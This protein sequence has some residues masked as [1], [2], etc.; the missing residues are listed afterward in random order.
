MGLAERDEI[1]NA[2]GKLVD[3][4]TFADQEGPEALWKND[5][6]RGVPSPGNLQSIYWRKRFPA[7]TAKDPDRDRCG[8]LWLCPAFPLDGKVIETA[9]DKVHEICLLCGFEPNIGLQLASP[10]CVHAFVMLVYDREVAGEDERAL[11]CHDQLLGYLAGL[12]IYP[13]RLALPALDRLPPGEQ[14]YGTFMKKIKQAL[15]PRGILR[16]VAMISRFSD[17]HVLNPDG[18]THGR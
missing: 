16:P 2:L 8:V 11:A 17:V 5:L 4:L 6:F 14:D 1:A 12:G 18:N 13:Y 7:P 3:G 15:D 9:L 10:R